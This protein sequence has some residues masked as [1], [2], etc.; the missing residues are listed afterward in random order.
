MVHSP[1][2][3]RSD[4]TGNCRRSL[5]L[6]PFFCHDLCTPGYS[7]RKIRLALNRRVSLAHKCCLYCLR[8]E[9][10]C[11]LAPGWS[12]DGFLPLVL[13][14]TEQETSRAPF[15]PDRYRN[16]DWHGCQSASDHCRS[17]PT[18]KFC[19]TRRPCS[20]ADYGALFVRISGYPHC[21]PAA[22]EAAHQKVWKEC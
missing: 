20:R 19:S 1:N 3:H 2:D 21:T 11:D 4:C 13:S 6:F 22:E 9:Y 14:Q 7:R 5:C 16:A 10:S 17:G 15:I 12:D 8:D 18:A